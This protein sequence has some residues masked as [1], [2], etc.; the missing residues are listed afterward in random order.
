MKTSKRKI[1]K[2]QG[3]KLMLVNTRHKKCNN[4]KKKKKQIKEI[5]S[6]YIHWEYMTFINVTVLFF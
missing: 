4:K 1:S 5:Q 3:R 2:C 6:Q